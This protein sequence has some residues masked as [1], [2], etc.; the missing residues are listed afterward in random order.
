MKLSRVEVL[1]RAVANA[2]RAAGVAHMAAFR[3][4]KAMQVVDDAAKAL[5]ELAGTTDSIKAF[6]AAEVARLDA[7]VMALEKAAWTPWRELGDLAE[8]MGAK[9]E[10]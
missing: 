2:H 1:R 4:R 7:S 9:G 10:R 8:F 6:V 5:A 3:S